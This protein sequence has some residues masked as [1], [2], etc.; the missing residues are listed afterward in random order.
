M[1]SKQDKKI[2][3]NRFRYKGI[4]IVLF[5]L[6]LGIVV[7]TSF[8]NSDWTNVNLTGD[9]LNPGTNPNESSEIK[10]NLSLKSLELDGV[11]DKVT[12]TSVSQVSAKIGKS[13]F[14]IKNDSKIILENYDGEIVFDSEK[15]IEL[16]GDADRIETEGGSYEEE[17]DIN[18]EDLEYENLKIEGIYI[19]KFDK[20]VSG[21][22]Q[23]DESRIHFRKKENL[24]I[25]RFQGIISSK[26][27]NN[28]IDFSG[29]AEK[30]K[31]GEYGV[32]S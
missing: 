11:F 21:I 10:A 1:T 8:F 9:F 25:K 29:I 12:F 22:I 17:T 30:I 26:G 7:Y 18:L 28:T 32:F 3:R 27:A 2:E 13:P 5:I 20:Q 16:D 4:I 6:V 19:R 14:T 24:L 15:I 31:M 23:K